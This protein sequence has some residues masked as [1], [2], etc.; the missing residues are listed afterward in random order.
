MLNARCNVDCVVGTG[1]LAR[2]SSSLQQQS[3]TS[4]SKGADNNKRSNRWGKLQ[5]LKLDTG[6]LR[7]VVIHQPNVSG[8]RRMAIK[9]QQT[10]DMLLHYWHHS[11]S[12]RKPLSFR[13]L[14]QHD[15]AFEGTNYRLS[16]V[17]HSLL[18]EVRCS[19][20][21]VCAL[22]LRCPEAPISCIIDCILLRCSC[23]CVIYC[24]VYLQ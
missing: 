22:A 21:S 13:G 3:P 23:R 4:T 1:G 9:K 19:L 6:G 16:L 12:K 2:Q 10:V 24:I 8:T 18:F 7:S 20:S 17:S 14:P 5:S 11:F 15:L